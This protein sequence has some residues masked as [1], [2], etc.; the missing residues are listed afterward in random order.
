MADTNLSRLD[1]GFHRL[2]AYPQRNPSLDFRFRELIQTGDDSALSHINAYHLA[3]N[4]NVDP[5]SVLVWL[6]Y[7][8]QAGLFDL[9]WV[10]RCIH[11]TGVSNVSGRLGLIG[12]QDS[13]MSCQQSFD[14]HSDQ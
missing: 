12:H 11:C 13:C 5:R 4:W 2:Q 8:S 14:V 9:N 10:T 7:S 6:L 1:Q 3:E